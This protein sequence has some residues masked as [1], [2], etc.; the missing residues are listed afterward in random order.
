MNRERL[1][2]VKVTLNER[3]VA[4]P[5]LCATNQQV[6]LFGSWAT[7]VDRPGAD[8]DIF[9][10]GPAENRKKTSLVDLICYPMDIV[11][12]ERWLGSELANHI[13]AYGVWLHGENNW[14]SRVFISR[15]AIAYKRRLI[16]ARINGVVRLWKTLATEYRIKHIVKLRRDIQRLFLMKGGE[17]V[18]PTPSLDQSWK[19]CGASV[20]SLEALLLENS[21][22]ELLSTEALNLVSDYLHHVS[23]QTKPI[24]AD[25]A[26][27]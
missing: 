3:D 15:K 18:K 25:R 10:V 9:C 16:Q 26:V 7:E 27:A 5:D 1:N 21:E 13:A 17:P 8:I 24:S 23:W 22:S 2:L 11:L 19:N 6:V 20:K 12:S 14:G 4:L